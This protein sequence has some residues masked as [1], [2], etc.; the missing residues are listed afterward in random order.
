MKTLALLPMLALACPVFAQG[1]AQSLQRRVGLVASLPLSDLKD[2]TTGSGVGLSAG[3]GFLQLSPNC[4]L[5]A[6]MEYRSF[7]SPSEKISLSDTGLDLHTTIK[8]GFYNR[9]GIGAERVKFPML[10]STIK[11]MGEFGFG[12][13]FDIPIGV[14]LYESHLAASTPTTTTLNFALSWYF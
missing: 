5:G 12:Y 11:L 6:F 4:T 8:G 2:L 10:P 13:R 3:W 14:E 7:S 9:L 1:S